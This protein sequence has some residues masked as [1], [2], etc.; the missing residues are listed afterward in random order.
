MS[1][2]Y[3]QINQ[4]KNMSQPELLITKNNEG[5][6]NNSSPSGSDNE[7]IIEASLPPPDIDQLYHM[8]AGNDEEE[9]EE[10]TIVNQKEYGKL[11]ARHLYNMENRLG[12]QEGDTV[13]YMFIN[14]NKKTQSLKAVVLKI[15]ERTK[16]IVAIAPEAEV[17]VGDYRN[18]EWVDG[19]SCFPTEETIGLYDEDEDDDED[20][21][22]TEDDS[23]EK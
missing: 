17:S 4:I 19:F 2:L 14:E 3:L 6:N 13:Y 1:I 5:K 12:Y 11:M 21:D 15:L 16:F 22:S 9:E 7:E 20:E 18:L 10:E 8:Y 23:T